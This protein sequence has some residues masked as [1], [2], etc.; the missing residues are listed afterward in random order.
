MC[1]VAVRALTRD[2][3]ADGRCAPQD[4]KQED[5]D[6]TWEGTDPRR[7]GASVRASHLAVALPALKYGS[8][9]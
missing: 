3:E 7:S 2:N 4:D 9:S 8:E 5:G 6:E 1:R